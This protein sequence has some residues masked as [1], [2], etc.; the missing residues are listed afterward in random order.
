MSS[1]LPRPRQLLTSLVNSIAAIP[2]TP[3]GPQLATAAG[4]GGQPPRTLGGAGAGVNHSNPLSL[5]PASHRSL[6]ATLHVLFP[7]LLL[8]ALDLLDRGLVTRLLVFPSRKRE[9][10][11]QQQQQQV[12]GQ[13]SG[14]DDRQGEV[15][16]QELEGE[17]DTEGPDAGSGSSSTGRVTYFV[18]SAA[19]AQRKHFGAAASGAN[20]TGQAYIVH[21]QAWNCTCAAFA[22]SAF[23]GGGTP[24]PADVQEEPPQEAETETDG[25]SGGGSASGWE[26]GGLS[27]DG[28]DGDGSE[29]VP[30]CK[31]L[32]AC[33]LAERWEV[34]G[35]YVVERMVEREEVAGVVADV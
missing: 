13:Q 28:T 7:S 12:A 35:R 16:A 30:C 8:P 10:K 29:G 18:R 27:S 34:L 33:V 31:H 14:G 3:Q 2:V 5:V 25:E 22:F 24:G 20:P 17:H 32:L 21:V 26:F 19:Q 1:S 23:P 15:S 11:Q 9:Q 4:D 6:L